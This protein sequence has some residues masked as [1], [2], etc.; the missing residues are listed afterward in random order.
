MKL[1]LNKDI[2]RMY[3]DKIN[4][5]ININQGI[6]KKSDFNSKKEIIT[7]HKGVK[8]LKINPNFR[9]LFFKIKRGPQI[10]TLKDAYYIAGE[11]GLSSGS[12]VLDCGG[13][14]GSITCVFANIVGSKGKVHSIERKKDFAEL[15]KKN[16]DLFGLKNVKVVNSDIKDLKIKVSFDAINLDLPNPSDALDFIKTNLKNGGMLS[17]YT[18]NTTQMTDFVNIAKEHNLILLNACELIKRDWK[19]DGIICHPKFNMLGHTGFILI[20]R[21]LEV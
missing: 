7:T 2:K 16:V 6:I 19:V 15:I 8:I 14:S 21:K 13:G 18:P 9:D 3:G 1:L 5:D 4:S 12:I 10:I 17:V 20:F 11:L